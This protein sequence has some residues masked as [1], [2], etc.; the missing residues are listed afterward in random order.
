VT[1]EKNQVLARLG[2][3]DTASLVGMAV[4]ASASA[5]RKRALLRLISDLN[6]PM[7]Q[8]RFV[9]KRLTEHL[10][11]SDLT[12]NFMAYKFFNRRPRGSGYVSQFEGGGDKWGDDGYI[13]TRDGAEEAMFDYSGTKAAPVN[14]H[15]DVLRRV[16]NFGKMS[17]LTFEPSIRPKYAAL[18]YARLLH[19]SAGQWG[20]SYM[21][22]K[23]HVKHNATYLHSDSFDEAGNARQ[24]ARLGDKV[25]S[26]LNMDR[27][28]AN[29]P[30]TMLKALYSTQQG[31]SLGAALQVPGLGRTSYIE[32]HVHGGLQFDRDIAK[33]VISNHELTNAEAELKKIVLNNKSFKVVSSKTLRET[34]EKFARKYGIV[35]AQV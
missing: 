35:V 25:T 2:A 21:V 8:A 32:S 13:T 17:E 10:Q 22:L 31:L 6:V 18:N 5:D 24:R 4:D 14:V 27:L 15:S 19:G 33:I 29:M 11:S 9:L 3:R 20:K 12:I 26:F 23:E 1:N 30:E 7:V 16:F 28:I 34:F